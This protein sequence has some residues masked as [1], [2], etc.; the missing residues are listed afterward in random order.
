VSA[1]RYMQGRAMPIGV[2]IGHSL[3]GAA[4]LAAAFLI[5]SSVISRKLRRYRRK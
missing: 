3:G 1:A 2:L 4:V 5:G